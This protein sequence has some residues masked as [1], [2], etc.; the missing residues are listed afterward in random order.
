MLR[1]RCWPRPKERRIIR[2]CE[3]SA[4]TLVQGD[5]TELPRLFPLASFDVVV[6]H[7]L[8]EFVESP[9]DVLNGIRRVLVPEHSLTSVIVR[10]RAGEVLMR[11]SRLAI[12]RRLK[13]I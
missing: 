12:W 8:L 1:R 3:G 6:C 9:L 5:A 4:V 10:N 2:S 7:H 11:P 13:A